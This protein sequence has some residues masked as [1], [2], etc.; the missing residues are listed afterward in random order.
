MQ[1]VTFLFPFVLCLSLSTGVIAQ[2]ANAKSVSIL[3]TPWQRQDDYTESH[4]PGKLVTEMKKTVT[5]L[6]SWLQ[7]SSPD[8]LAY[9]P[10]WCGAYYSNKDNVVPIFRHELRA[11]FYTGEAGS[12]SAEPGR[13]GRFVITA[14]DFGTLQRPFDLNGHSYLSLPPMRTL[15][16]GIRYS[17]SVTHP[18]DPTLSGRVSRVWLISNTD[19][20]PYTVISRQ[21]Y[22]KESLLEIASDKQNLK[23]DLQQRIPVKSAQQEQATKDRELQEIGS[24]YSGAMR[25]NL[26]RRYLASYKPDSVYFKEV[27]TEQSAPFDADSVLLDSLLSK[28]LPEYLSRPACVSVP[29]ASFRQFEDSLPGSRMLVKWNMNYFNR[30]ISLARPQFF[31]VSWSYDVADAVAADIDRHLQ[32]KMDLCNLETLLGK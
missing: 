11:G 26:E 4:L 30:A 28:S 25:T 5:G 14:N 27:F 1:S 16:Q 9:T 17:D 2:S 7:Q 21:E 10:A 3:V 19:S 8:S 24:L 6:A 13:E 18:E 31:T 22:L 15:Y 29:A 20:L 12:L 23:V 32:A